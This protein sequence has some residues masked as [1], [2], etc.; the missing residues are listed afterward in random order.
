MTSPAFEQVRSIAADIFAVPADRITAQSSPENVD[1]WDSTQHLSFVLALEERF[2]L[3]FSPEEM[4][5]MRDVGSTAKII[6]S[7]IQSGGN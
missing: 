2:N 6:E 7:K 5:Q 4:E 1:A 3:Q